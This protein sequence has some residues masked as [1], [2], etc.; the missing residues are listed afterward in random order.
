MSKLIVTDEL[1]SLV[2]P[3]LPQHEPSPKG[4]HP[5]VSDRVCLTGILFVLRT[6]IRWND[7]PVEMGCGS[8]STSSRP[9]SGNS[10]TSCCWPSCVGQRRSTSAG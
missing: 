4:G 8:G 2:E 5:P 1:W 10:A 7:L 6:G 3:I 9:G